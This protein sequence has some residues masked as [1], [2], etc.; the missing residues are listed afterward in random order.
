MTDDD[1]QKPITRKDIHEKAIDDHLDRINHEF[2]RGFELLAKYPRSVSIFGSSMEPEGSEP[3]EQAYELAK[4]IVKETGYAV[5]CGGGP[6]VMEAANRGA[7]E[8]G[9]PSIG[10]RIN[11][12]RERAINQYE[13]DG[14]D[15]TY[16]FSRKVMLSFAA[17]AY[18]FMPGGFGTMDE[19]WSILTLIQTNHI[20]RVP[21]ILFGSDY[22]KPLASFIEKTMYDKYHTIDHPDMELYEITDDYDKVINMVKKAPTSDW[23]RDIN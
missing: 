14:A 12:A 21:V 13:T 9:G 5:I 7:A 10:L 18:I 8:A 15:F 16:F 4:R 2:R 1:T 22:W 6:G 17:E 19:L 23:W 20:P 3:Y 11:L